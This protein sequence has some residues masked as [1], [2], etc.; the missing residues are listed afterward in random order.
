MLL[1]FILFLT[2]GWALSLGLLQ[3]LLGQRLE[4]AQ[5]QQLGRN[6]AEVIKLSEMALE[7]FPPALVAELSGLR[8][9]TNIKL[10]GNKQG[11]RDRELRLELCKQLRHCPEVRPNKSGSAG[12]WVELLS[13]LEQVWLFAALPSR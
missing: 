4:R 11:N 10:S 9:A 7:R 12:V 5:M 6:L 1:R 8:L 13:P 3:Q 2:L